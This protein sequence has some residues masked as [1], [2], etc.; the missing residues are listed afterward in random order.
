M[1][2]LAI[3]AAELAQIQTDAAAAACDQS[4]TIK[5]AA[6]TPTASGGA[7]V[8]WNTVATVQAGMAEPSSSQLQNYG[9]LVGSLAAWQVRF[10]VNTNVQELDQLVI[11][12]QT[13]SVVKVLTPR[14]YPALLTV[15]AAEVK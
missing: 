12:S 10:P 9:Y 7:T 15:L 8:V 3:S 13:L 2:M 6:R 4:C 11:A 14:S 5:R 1:P